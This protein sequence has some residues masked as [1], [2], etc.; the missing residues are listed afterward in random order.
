MAAGL[1]GRWVYSTSI[2]G[3]TPA[4][5]VQVLSS[6]SKGTDL[7]EEVFCTNS[8]MIAFSSPASCAAIWLIESTLQS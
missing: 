2:F 5:A 6:L 7:G 1:A 3:S 8:V 4:Q